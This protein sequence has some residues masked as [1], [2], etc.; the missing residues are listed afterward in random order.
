M[1]VCRFSNTNLSFCDVVVGP[2]AFTFMS[3]T[4]LK[5]EPNRWPF[6]LNPGGN[7]GV[8]LGN[9]TAVPI[10]RM[11]WQKTILLMWVSVVWAFTVLVLGK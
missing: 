5:L 8:V 9:Y 1:T 11:A 6:R 10:P 7:L 3:D 2:K 4:P